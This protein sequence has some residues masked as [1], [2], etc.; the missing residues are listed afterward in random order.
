MPSAGEGTA[1][2]ADNG[3]GAKQPTAAASSASSSD[4]TVTDAHGGG[5]GGG[6]GNDSDESPEAP[7]AAAASRPFTSSLRKLLKYLRQMSDHLIRRGTAAW[8]PGY[9][10]VL[11]S[12]W[13]GDD[14][15]KWAHPLSLVFVDDSKARE[16]RAMSTTLSAH[17]KPYPL[18]PYWNFG[19]LADGDCMVRCAA[20]G[21]FACKNDNLKPIFD[22]IITCGRRDPVF[23]TV[24]VADTNARQQEK[25]AISQY[26]CL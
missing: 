6:S 1:S 15:D 12:D 23:M 21:D 19:V 5:G 13:E 11:V 18:L 4:A 3:S 7:G 8:E 24:D 16:E 25:D 14:E 10:A 2:N 17:Q 22:A 9:H 26:R 20:M